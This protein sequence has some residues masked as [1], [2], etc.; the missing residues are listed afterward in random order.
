MKP[1]IAVFLRHPQCSM[2]CVNG[3]TTALE[4][5]YS[6]RLFASQHLELDTFRQADIIAFPGGIGDSDSFDR[7]F[8]DKRPILD[9]LDR[10]GRYLGICM[11]A[12]WAGKKY[13][14]ILDGG[15]CIQYIKRP[16]TTIRRSYS[17]TAKVTWN[18][19]EE[20]MFLYDGC[21]IVDSKVE[22]VSRYQNGDVMAGY[23][24]RIG[25][26]GCHPESEESWYNKKY[27][28]PRWHEGRHHKLLLDFVDGLMER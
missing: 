19:M 11:G 5:K 4:D 15:D 9:Y 6:I 2:Q 17:T 27:L 12:Y 24:E 21:S 28:V 14:D 20:D 13:L 23:Y 3:M 7:F 8:P 25:I 26:I 1:R 18:G 16:D 10:G 22:A